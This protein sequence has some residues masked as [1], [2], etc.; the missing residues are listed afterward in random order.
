MQS[1]TVCIASYYATGYYCPQE[2][3]HT[4]QRTNKSNFKKPGVPTT[5]WHTPG[6]KYGKWTMFAKYQINTYICCNLNDIVSKKMYEAFVL[7]IM[8]G[9]ACVLL[10][11]FIVGPIIIFII[12]LIGEWLYV[13]KAYI[14]FSHSPQT[15]CLLL[16]HIKTLYTKLYHYWS[17]W[18][19][20]MMIPFWFIQ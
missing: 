13:P 8:H 3:M 2:Q 19:L 4:Y 7:P 5:D 16:G 11:I 10:E 14:Q 17:P 6:L 12:N 20:Y 9:C 15:L 18:M 1:H